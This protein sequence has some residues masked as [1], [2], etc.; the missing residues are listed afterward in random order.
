MIDIIEWLKC[1]AAGLRDEC[2]FET[3]KLA[4]EAIPELGRLRAMEAKL[5]KTRDGAR[6]IP[7]MPLWYINH[8]GKVEKFVCEVIDKAFDRWIGR[9]WPDTWRHID[10]CYSTQEAAEAAR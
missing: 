7:P 8:G 6:V 2:C 10:E 5:P 9:K 1:E 3:A 4:D